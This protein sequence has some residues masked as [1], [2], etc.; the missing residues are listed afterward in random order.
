MG[1]GVSDA[2]RV[3]IGIMFIAGAQVFTA[4]QFVL[5]ESIMERYSMAPIRVVGWEGIF[6][7]SVTVLGM[8]I[9]HLAIGRTDAGRYGYF[10][11][12]EGLREVFEI[13]AIGISSLLTM[14]SIG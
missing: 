4:T 5:E 2:A 3:F 12:R 13:R 10:D 8:I 11:A 1:D 9:L 14:I 7:L 6:G